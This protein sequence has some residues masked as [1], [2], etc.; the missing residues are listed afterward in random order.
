MK[1]QNL[2]SGK[3]KE[4][5]SICRLLKILLRVLRVTTVMIWHNLR[6]THRN[7]FFWIV[8]WK[9]ILILPKLSCPGLDKN[10]EFSHVWC[11]LVIM[12]ASYAIVKV[13]VTEH[14]DVTKSHSNIITMWRTSAIEVTALL[15]IHVHNS[16]HM[17]INDRDFIRSYK[18]S[19]SRAERCFGS[20]FKY[21]W[22]IFL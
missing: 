9:E 14:N 3:N 7:V 22:K 10:W 12:D 16:E 6:K 4:I 15:K 5:I 19:K 1:C 18:N 20:V 8:S 21:Y 2:F 17:T 11:A 13:D